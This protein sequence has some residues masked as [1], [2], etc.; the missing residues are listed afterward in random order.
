MVFN[1][2][3]ATAHM[4]SMVHLVCLFMKMHLLALLQDKCLNL[5]CCTFLSKLS[6]CVR[7]TT[8]QCFANTY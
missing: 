7:Y 5:L 2:D 4:C 1:Y 6:G 8:E 3:A